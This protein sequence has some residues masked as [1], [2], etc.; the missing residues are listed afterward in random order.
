M[1]SSGS[2]GVA[3]LGQM[4]VHSENVASSDTK[5]K[6]SYAAASNGKMAV[7]HSELEDSTLQFRRLRDNILS[8]F[9]EFEDLFN[10]TQTEFTRLTGLA[11]E[12][13]GEDVVGK[14][15]RERCKQELACADLIKKIKENLDALGEMTRNKLKV[16]AK[17][18][19]E[20]R[21]LHEEQ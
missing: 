3:V 1:T 12:K 14:L 9:R 20:A 16:V 5:S 17:A 18:I 8:N 2:Q 11:G 4:D 21:Q 15:D 13:E 6:Q 19:T 10:D 7:I